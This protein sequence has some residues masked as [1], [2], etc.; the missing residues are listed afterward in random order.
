M[1]LANR[2]GLGEF[3]ESDPALHRHF[4]AIVPST[5][6]PIDELI[7]CSRVTISIDLVS[8]TLQNLPFVRDVLLRN[9]LDGT[10]A[11]FISLSPTVKSIPA[12][13]EPENLSLPGYSLPN[14]IYFIHG[15]LLKDHTGEYDF[16]RME[17]ESLN[18]KTM[19]KHQLLVRKIVAEVLCINPTPITAHSDFFLM[20]GTSLL[21]GQ[22]CYR[23][24][25]QTG[26]N[27][28]IADLFTKSTI[29][30]IASMI[31]E[32]ENEGIKRNLIDVGNRTNTEI[33]ES[34][35]AALQLYEQDAKYHKAKRSH[36]Q[37]HPLCLIVQ[38]IPFIVLSSVGSEDRP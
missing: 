27:I 30:G 19:T 18:A 26:I 31:E 6:A 7:P 33:D 25:R 1:G 32:K 10:L 24:R 5:S 11:A 28:E 14:P 29:C 37:N 23:L 38:A 35:T 8:R 34:S 20:G 15:P 3:R 17:N 2:L 9:N 16:Q 36:S 21:V 12:I 22:L 4:E 13:D